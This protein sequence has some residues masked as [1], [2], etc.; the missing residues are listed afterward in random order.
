[1]VKDGIMLS[2]ELL[3]AIAPGASQRAYLKFDDYGTLHI[4]DR[5]EDGSLRKDYYVEKVIEQEGYSGP[6][7]KEEM[8]AVIRKKKYY[9]GLFIFALVGLAVCMFIACF[10]IYALRFAT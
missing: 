5:N 10:C 6:S 7:R 4:L 1:M 3:N 9:N 2:K 8:D